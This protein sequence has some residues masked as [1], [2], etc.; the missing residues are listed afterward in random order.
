MMLVNV[1][2]NV[3]LVGTRGGLVLRLQ[4]SLVLLLANGKAKTK[5]AIL[6]FLYC[7]KLYFYFTA[8]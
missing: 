8:R 5:L 3:S 6:V 7:E 1:K 4:T 2:L